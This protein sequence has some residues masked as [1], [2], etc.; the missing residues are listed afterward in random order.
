LLKIEGRGREWS[1]FSK[2]IT[3]QLIILSTVSPKVSLVL[4]PSGGFSVKKEILKLA[5][6][7]SNDANQNS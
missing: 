7:K 2:S 3:S 5:K 4:K 6:T 1:I